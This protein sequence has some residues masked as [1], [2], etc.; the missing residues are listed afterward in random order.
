MIKIQHFE[1]FQISLALHRSVIA[2][3]YTGISLYWTELCSHEGSASETAS[4]QNLKLA[5]LMTP[6]RNVCKPK[7]ALNIVQII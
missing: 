4:M 1:S 7:T 2:W 5:L 3:E 6:R